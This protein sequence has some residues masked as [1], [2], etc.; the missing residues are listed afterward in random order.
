[1]NHSIHK[2]ISGDYEIKIWIKKDDKGR[3]SRVK[4]FLINENSV[5][6]GD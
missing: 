6:V 5:Q 1:M 3:L 4:T 2:Q